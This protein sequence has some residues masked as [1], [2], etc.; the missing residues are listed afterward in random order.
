MT[1]APLEYS[2]PVKFTPSQKCVLWTA[3][4]LIATAYKALA[5]TCAVEVRGLE[6][7][8]DCP[9][10]SRPLIVAVWHECLGLAA[11][12]HRNTG[13]H[14]LTSYSF[15]GELAARI[16]RHF[17]LR[18]VRGSSSRGGSK[19]LSQL[20]AALDVAPAVGFTLDGPR[21]PRRIA[22]PGVAILAARAQ[23]PIIPNAFTV[24]RCWR[25]NS[26]DRLIIPK[27]FAK[28]ICAFGAPISPPPNCS[29]DA[30]ETTRL[31]VERA[32][33]ALH[34]QI[35]IAPLGAER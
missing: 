33:N 2:S 24:T 6:H 1:P 12:W 17:G 7:W 32:L 22:K 21:G 35:D 27:P 34:D 20:L 3:P 14:T 15:D 26:W 16:V 25:M 11:C 10:Q 13:Y 18:A 30:I 23:C 5:Y 9:P 19:A 4:P 29:P 28:L 8:H 31:E